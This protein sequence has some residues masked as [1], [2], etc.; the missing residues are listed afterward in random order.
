MRNGVIVLMLLL[1]LPR[2]VSAQTSTRILTDWRTAPPPQGALELRDGRQVRFTYHF[3]HNALKDCVQVADSL[4]C[5][6]ESGDVLRFDAEALRMN[7]EEIVPGRATTITVISPDRILIGT[8]AGEISE[9][10]PITLGLKHIT[11]ADGKIIWLSGS[12]SPSNQSATIVAV[13]DNYPEVLPWPGEPSKDYDK[14]SAAL[15]IKDMHPYYVRVYAN[16]GE[17]S[18][19]FNLGK[20][21]VLPTAY[22]LDDFGR[23]WMGSDKGEWGGECS[24]MDLSTGKVHVVSTET[25]GVLGFVRSGDGRLLAYGGMSHLGMHEGYIAQ[26]TPQGMQSLR[27]FERD[28]WQQLRSKKDQNTK[29]TRPGQQVSSPEN[30]PHGPVDLMVDDA[31]GGGFWV[32]SAHILYRTD[33]NFQRW[34]KIADLGGRWYGGRRYSMGNTPTINRLMVD[35]SRPKAQLAV[36]GRDGLERVSGADVERVSFA[37][38]LES[39]VID[40][41]RTSIGTLLLSDDSGHAAWRLGDGHWQIMKF[42]PDRQPSVEGTDWDFAEPFADDGTGILAFVGSNLTPGERDIVRLKTNNTAE[43]IKTWEDR[44]SEWD[45]SFLLSPEGNL[46]RIAEDSV[47][48][49]QESGWRVAGHSILSDGLE[50]RS[51]LSGRRYL[52][53]GSKGA[54]GFFLDVEFGQFLRLR[55]NSDNSYELAPAVY[56]SNTAP[57]AVFDAIPDRDG[58]FL[59]ATAHGLLRFR[60]EDGAREPIPSPPLRDE[61]KSLCRDGDGRLW[62]AGDGVYVSSDE[63]TSWEP[64][65]LPM[66]AKTYTKRVRP[67]PE[68]PRGLIL[69]LHDQG[70]VFVDW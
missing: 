47:W 18:F 8:Q 67:N 65:K 29:V 20:K 6:T 63:G 25:L 7:A 12:G 52:S 31:G 60:P 15:E 69:A 33:A 48:V 35:K 70:A 42:F 39:P 44:S 19:S 51:V 14:R 50:Q 32:V 13:V 9:V 27:R 21:L 5:L 61:I 62:A 66:L 26:V 59:V 38:Q 57:T 55:R 36:M 58:W 37:G 41:W 17:K 34:A 64:V 56:P 23:L 54:T 49:Q 30:M 24:Y 68:S 22:F 10:D 1:V 28:D 46:L 45:T 3:N 16:G 11:T 40:I 4:V 2:S 53:A 43:V